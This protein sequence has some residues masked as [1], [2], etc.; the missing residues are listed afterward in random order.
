MIGYDNF[1]FLNL[2]RKCQYGK[3]LGTGAS[4]E[5]KR[6]HANRKMAKRTSV[7]HA[8]IITKQ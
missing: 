8:K 6:R 3:L 7:R 2:G 4:V 5:E 1:V